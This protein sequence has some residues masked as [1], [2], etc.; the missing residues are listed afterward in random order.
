MT[1]EDQKILFEKLGKQMNYTLGLP[2]FKLINDVIY[3]LCTKCKKY[4]PMTSK[5]FPRRNNVKCGYGSHCKECEKEKES[6]RIRIPSFNENGELY[7]HVCKTYKDCEKERK[8]INDRDR[9]LSGCK[10]RALKN[11]IPF[12]LTKEQLIELF[13]KQN[14]KCALSNLEMLK[15]VKILLMFLSIEL[16]QGE[17]ILYLTFV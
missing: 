11:N 16:N 4:K 15:Q 5:F 6:K 14:G 7:C 3:K 1:S 12:D 9:L 13:E 8:K 17:H 10:T 2:N